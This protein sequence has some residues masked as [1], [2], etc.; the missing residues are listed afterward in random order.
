MKVSRS[1]L[2]LVLLSVGVM[3]CASSVEELAP[4]MSAGLVGEPVEI[5]SPVGA[6]NSVPQ[7]KDES[8]IQMELGLVRNIVT[9]CAYLADMESKEGKRDFSSAFNECVDAAVEGIQGAFDE[10]KSDGDM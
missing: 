6:N 8:V 5:T 2:V 4:N 7:A 3:G 9:G 1:V 10:N